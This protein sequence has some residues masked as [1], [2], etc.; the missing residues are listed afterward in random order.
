MKINAVQFVYV[1][2]YYKSLIPKYEKPNSNIN[3]SKI[4]NL[5]FDVIFFSTWKNDDDDTVI[6]FT[7]S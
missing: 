7:E 2:Y 6:I 4:S 1:K 5:P 3:I